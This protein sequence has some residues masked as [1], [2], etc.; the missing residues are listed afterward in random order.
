VLNLAI[1]LNYDYDENNPTI[2]LR[3]L[4]IRKP[5]R[6][7]GIRADFVTRFEDLLN[8]DNILIS[9]FTKEMIQ[10]VTALRKIGK[11]I[12]F[13][14]SE[15]LWALPY[16]TEMFNLCDYIVCCSTELAAL[17]AARLTSSFTKVYVIPDMAEGPF[18]E[19]IPQDV[20]PLRVV[21]S[22]M[23]GNAY[24]AT[25][26]KPIIE[27]LG[28]KLIVISEWADAD[29]KWSRDTYL[30]EMAK[31]DIAVCPQNVALQPAKSNVKL[32]TA[33]SLGLPVIASPLQAYKEII[34]N[35]EN[36]FVAD[37][38][39]EWRD[40][41]TQL[42]SLPL[43]Q[44]ISERARV[45][46]QQYTPERIADAWGEL[47]IRAPYPK[48]AFINNTLRVKYMSYGDKI[49]E[50]LRFLGYT[51]DTFRYEDIDSLPS[52]YDAYVF[53]EVRYDS[54]QISDVHPRILITRENTNI[55]NLPQ[56]DLVVC[57][58]GLLAIWKNRGFVHLTGLENFD[59]R[60]YPEQLIKLANHKEW[61]VEARKT[62]NL[63]LHNSDIDSFY[64]LMLP[65]LRWDGGSRDR[66]H[67]KF[68]MQHAKPGMCVLDIGSADGWLSLY[69]A[70]E[71]CKV[72]ALEFV[73]R[74]LDWTEKQATRLGVQLETKFG[75]LEELDTTLAGRKFDIIMAYEILEHVDY[76][77]LPWY[78]KKIENLL[79][80]DGKV[81][82]S[83]PRQDLNDN[84]QHVWS[85]NEGLINKIFKNKP[86]VSVQWVPLPDH[87]VPGNW[88]IVYSA[89]G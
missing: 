60:Q 55:N 38:E 52:N 73:D 84:Q 71:G 40:A 66:D 45:D 30:Q 86:N 81:L 18:P 21:W 63:N 79:E 41:L 14:H 43:R 69:L 76:L 8:F 83:L 42:K 22:G 5:L 89:R 11:K 16:Q 77:S 9:H 67:I 15:H 3:R 51:V 61:Q 4:N 65:E 62:H 85:P 59:D 75:F 88:F 35:G 17:T 2:R 20:E 37:S 70:K 36:G 50:D 29:I 80:I 87:G 19:H 13:C 82:I 72:T 31:C 49:L 23:G 78:L 26:L 33:M 27:S 56:F 39:A 28:M 1:Y 25:S 32:S 64:S 57:D 10:E 46:G 24:H 54:E 74:G 34:K 47:L 44:K 68:T 48:I 12:F 6:K 7:A 53:I 58:P